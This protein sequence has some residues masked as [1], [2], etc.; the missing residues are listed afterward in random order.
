MDIK[1]YNDYL[2]PIS[3]DAIAW[4]YMSFEKVYDLLL[5][6][7]IYFTR[8]DFFN[9]PLEGLS[10][11]LRSLL[12]LKN[13]SKLEGNN[14]IGTQ[15]SSLEISQVNK[16]QIQV[17]QEGIFSSCW[18]LTEGEY[19][20]YESLA[21]WQLYAD[22]YSFV[23]KIPFKT[24][25]N[26][27]SETLQDNFTD[28]EINASYY[29]RID[30]LLLFEDFIKGYKK[31]PMPALIKDKSYK[32]ENEVRFLLTRDGV[33]DSNNNRNGIKLK[34]KTSIKES[35]SIKLLCHP[36]MDISVFHSFYVSFREIGINLEYSKLLTS[37]VVK[38]LIL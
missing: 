34:L 14:D 3:E 28:P 37:E 25:L 27:I 4:R 23:L 20:H 26:L 33:L 29:G 13:I 18:Y 17:W 12:F 35:E 30:Y 22:K 5:N 24:I 11:N 19:N 6:N 8:L 31:A 38:N 9:D 32:F 7:C 36:E 2:H 15:F 10:K 21:M 1:H 16:K